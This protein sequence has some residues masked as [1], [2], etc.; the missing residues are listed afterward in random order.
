MIIIRYL[1]NLRVR[2]TAKTVNICRFCLFVKI[3]TRPLYWCLSGLPEVGTPYS[4]MWPDYQITFL[5]TRP[6]YAMSSSQSVDCQILHGNVRQVDL[7]QNIRRDNNNVPIAT[8]WRQA[9]GRGHS[10]ATLRSEPTTRY[11]RLYC[12]KQSSRRRMCVKTTTF[13]LV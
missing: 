11:R 3:F 10:R 13:E 12:Y 1:S 7:V 2:R 8:L 6:C 4:D 9:I 5:H